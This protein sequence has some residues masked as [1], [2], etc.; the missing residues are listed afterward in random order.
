MTTLAYDQ[1]LGLNRLGFR[2]RDL[3]LRLS[4]QHSGLG[5]EAS[6]KGLR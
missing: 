4:V 6:I 3:G 5:A 2:V 1:G